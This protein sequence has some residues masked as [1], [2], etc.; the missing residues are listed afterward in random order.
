MLLTNIVIALCDVCFVLTNLHCWMVPSAVVG[1]GIGPL[2]DLII[3]WEVLGHSGHALPKEQPEVTYIEL[4][5]EVK[6]L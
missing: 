2:W 3:K 5:I 6:K 4:L 1:T